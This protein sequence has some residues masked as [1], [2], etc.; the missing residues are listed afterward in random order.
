V[1]DVIRLEAAEDYVEIFTKAGKHLKQKPLSYF[2]AHLDPEQFIR[3]HRSS[4]VAIREISKL[5]A[6]SK[7]SYILILKDGTEVNVSK[8]GMKELKER[9]NF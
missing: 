4:M 2:E 5:E 8:S 7:D 6:Y 1:D 3:V 9:L